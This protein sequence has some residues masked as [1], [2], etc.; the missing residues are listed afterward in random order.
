MSTKPVSDTP[1]LPQDLLPR[2]QWFYYSFLP[3]DQVCAL[4]CRRGWGPPHPLL[5]GKRGPSPVCRPTNTLH[6]CWG[7]A[8]VAC[9][10]LIPS[11]HRCTVAFVEREQSLIQTELNNNNAKKLILTSEKSNQISNNLFFLRHTNG[12]LRFP[13][14]PHPV[15]PAQ[16][17]SPVLPRKTQLWD[18]PCELQRAAARGTLAVWRGEEKARRRLHKRPRGSEP[19]R[20][21]AQRWGRHRAGAGTAHSLLTRITRSHRASAG[22]HHVLA[23]HVEVDAAMGAPVQSMARRGL[24]SP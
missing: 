7:E 15:I 22:V 19:A 20:L 21:Q 1:S 18:T 23:V 8:S 5:A 9:R 12:A 2:K 17:H 13:A 10:Q 16:T 6:N 11:P 3:S 4:V 14:Q 24:R